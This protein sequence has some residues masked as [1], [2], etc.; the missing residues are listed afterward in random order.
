MW[1]SIGWVDSTEKQRATAKTK[2][3]EMKYLRQILSKQSKIWH[4][5]RRFCKSKSLSLRRSL[6]KSKKMYQLSQ[7]KFPLPKRLKLASKKC[8]RPKYPWLSK[9]SRTLRKRQSKR[10]KR[11]SLRSS[12]KCRAKS[13]RS[14]RCSPRRSRKTRKRCNSTSLRCSIFAWSSRKPSKPVWCHLWRCRA[15]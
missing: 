13:R 12:R 7:R 8:S 4:S 6:I 15:R 11:W 10:C 5:K 3:H 9:S 2:L 1:E 14:V